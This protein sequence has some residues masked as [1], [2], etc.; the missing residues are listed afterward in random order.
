MLPRGRARGMAHGER[1]EEQRRCRTLATD[2][3]R[4]YHHALQVKTQHRLVVTLRVHSIGTRNDEL[5][6]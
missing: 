2:D 4:I 5:D 6:T 1:S 3:L